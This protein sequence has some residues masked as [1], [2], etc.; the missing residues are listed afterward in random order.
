MT[1]AFSQSTGRCTE[2]V[3]PSPMQLLMSSLSAVKLDQPLHDRKP[4]PRAV[5]RA[6]VGRARLEE[7][8]AHVR[9][10]I[11]ADADASIF[12][13]KHHGGVLRLAP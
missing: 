2:T 1:V 10:V 13:L 11:F 6:I 4:K 8:I 7:R 12:D 5:M 3:V 9:Q